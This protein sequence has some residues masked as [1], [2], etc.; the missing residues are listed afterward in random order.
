MIVTFDVSLVRP[1]AALVAGARLGHTASGGTP[2][3][4]Q[5]G[6]PGDGLMYVCRSYL[7]VRPTTDDQGLSAPLLGENVVRCC[8]RAYWLRGGN[9]D[10]QFYQSI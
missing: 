3:Q 6:N 4:V 10:V 8:P 9:V 7:L 1:L 5:G 2:E